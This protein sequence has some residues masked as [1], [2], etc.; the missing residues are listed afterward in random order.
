MS[1]PANTPSSAVID[2]SE[3]LRSKIYA[4]FLRLGFQDLQGLTAEDYITLSIVS[5]YLDFKIGE[6][7]AEISAELELEG[8][9]PITPDAEAL[10]TII[11][12]SEDTAK[13]VCSLQQSILDQRE[14][15]ELKEEKR[16]YEEISLNSK[17]H[18]LTM[19]SRQHHIAK[20][21]DY[22]ILKESKRLQERSIESSR[23]KERPEGFIF[24]STQIHGLQTT[25]FYSRVVTIE[26]TPAALTG[27]PLANT[28][29]AL[30]RVPIQGGALRKV[31]PTNAEH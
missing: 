20:T 13:S 10:R 23:P 26:T 28:D 3:N 11:Q 8:V 29:L 5:R 21:S 1:V 2:V 22:E 17:Q 12:T 16:A 30:E 24:H 31:T 6:V 25:N 15:E 9:R 27:G 18:E 19:K 14:Q 7:W 4:L